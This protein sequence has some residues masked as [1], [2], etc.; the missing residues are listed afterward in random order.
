MA[1]LPLPS[2]TMPRNQPARRRPAG[3]NYKRS[4]KPPWKPERGQRIMGIP[5]P[6]AFMIVL[7]FVV[8][9]IVFG[10]F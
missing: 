10:V 5:E 1:R 8:L 2:P 3:T 9:L 6:V 7:A 4:S